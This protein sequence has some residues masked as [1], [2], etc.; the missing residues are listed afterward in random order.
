MLPRWYGKSGECLKD[1]DLHC[2]KL[3][4]ADGDVM[5]ARVCTALFRDKYFSKD[6]CLEL[7]A[8]WNR[9]K[10]GFSELENRYP[11]D[12]ELLSLEASMATEQKDNAFALE[13]FKKLGPRVDISYWRKKRIFSNAY[14]RAK[15]EQIDFSLAPQESKM[16]QD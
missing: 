11:N 7:G 15:L 3:P 5:Y 8:D 10:R 14:T 6:F 1:L 12:L 9:I 16:L 2:D 4:E 13:A